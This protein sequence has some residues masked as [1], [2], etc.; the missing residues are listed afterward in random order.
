PPARR[1]RRR[2]PRSAWSDRWRREPVGSHSRL[3]TVARTANS[4]GSVAL[5]DEFDGFLVDLDGVVWIGREPVP[6]SAEAL[7]ALLSAGKRIACV[8]NTPGRRPA[9]YADRLRK[10][11]VEVA[12]EQIVT[13]G[14]VVA[15]LA[16]EA[17]GPGGS[18]FVIGAAA[19][20][21]MVAA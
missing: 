16:G 12:E 7:T 18:A 14:V 4:L 9:V 3:C 17:A 2:L 8:P 20:K 5:A 11:G 10:M 19:L 13:A 21:E 6:G 1:R 15:R